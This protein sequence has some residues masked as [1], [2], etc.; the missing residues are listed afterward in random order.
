MKLDE[1]VG[2]RQYAKRT[3]AMAIGVTDSVWS[4]LLLLRTAVLPTPCQSEFHAT[5]KY[6]SR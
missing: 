4:V 6:L 2:R 5:P 1:Q 3:P